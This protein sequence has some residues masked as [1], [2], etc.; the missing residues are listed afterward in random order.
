MK[1]S[2]TNSTFESSILLSCFSWFSASSWGPR[3]VSAVSRIV[4]VISSRSQWKQ[5]K[6]AGAT[7]CTALVNQQNQIISYIGITKQWKIKIITHHLKYWSRSLFFTLKSATSGPTLSATVDPPGGGHLGIFRWVCAARDS[8]LAPRSKE[9][10]PYNWY[11][12]LE[13]GQFFDTPF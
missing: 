10:F 7:A 11:P 12:V 9:N 5:N 1:F 13:M 4:S 8:K 6:V 2:I 3:V